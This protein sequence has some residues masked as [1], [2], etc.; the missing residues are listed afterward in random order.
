MSLRQPAARFRLWTALFLTTVLLL[1]T[2]PGRD[3]SAQEWSAP[4]TVYVDWA[5]HTVDGLFLD[6]WRTHQQHLGDPI[7][8]EFTQPELEPVLPADRTAADGAETE[9]D[10]DDVDEIIVQFFENGSIAYLPDNP[11]GEQVEMVPIGE[12]AAAALDRDYRRAFRA[13]DD[14]GDSASDCLYVEETDQTIRNGFLTFW[15]TG[16]A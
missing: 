15:E 11:P 3:A 7:T 5:G 1:S 2:A 16:D 6:F 13:V 10:D 9:D 14:C 4:T 12:T 8:E